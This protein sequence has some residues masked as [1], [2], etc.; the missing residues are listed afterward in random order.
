MLHSKWIAIL[1]ATTMI[2][3]C[4]DGRPGSGV[5]H[6][7]GSLNKEDIGTA[8]GAIAGGVIGYQFGGGAG[9][10]LATVGGVLLGGMLGNSIGKSLDNA[11]RAAYDQ[12][13]QHALESGRRQHWRNPESGHY[14]TVTPKRH[15]TDNSGRSC[16]EYTQ[17]IYIDGR[18]NSGHGT[19]CREADGSWMIID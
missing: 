7:G 5:M 3:A 14:G 2:S 16:R 11:D 9:Q 13:S 6:G 1:L 17:T 19:A 8:A 10:A 12:A 15:Y 4:T 18:K